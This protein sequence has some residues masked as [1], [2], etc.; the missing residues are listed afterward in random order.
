MSTDRWDARY[1]A[2]PTQTT[3]PRTH[4]FHRHSTHP[5]ASYPHPA[6]LSLQHSN[7]G[8]T[9]ISYDPWHC[10]R[11]SHTLP[12]PSYGFY[13]LPSKNELFFGLGSLRTARDSASGN[14]HNKYIEHHGRHRAIPDCHLFP[15]I[16]NHKAHPV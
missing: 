13:F 6:Y 4:P 5:Q 10:Y 15:V 7:S 16:L 12:M 9:L 8:P 11:I 14:R 3:S 2:R 1:K